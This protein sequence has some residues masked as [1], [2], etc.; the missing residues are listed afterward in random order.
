MRGSLCGPAMNWWPAHVVTLRPLAFSQWRWGSIVHESISSWHLQ[1]LCKLPQCRTWGSERRPPHPG[2]RW[3]GDLRWRTWRGTNT[4]HDDCQYITVLPAIMM[5][6]ILF[7]YISDIVVATVLRSYYCAITSIKKHSVKVSTEQTRHSKEKET[8][9]NASIAMRK[10]TEH[11]HNERNNVKMWRYNATP[12]EVFTRRRHL[13]EEEQV[14]GGGVH[15]QVSPLVVSNHGSA[16]LGV[17]LGVEGV[18]SA[19]AVFELLHLVQLQ[20]AQHGEGHARRG[21]RARFST[22]HIY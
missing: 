3:C 19:A 1:P 20:R 4:E 18:R 10:T 12:W 15:L 16:G 21:S 7:S 22:L 5:D 6:T 13:S 11:K 17:V 2:C 9:K 14:E 8:W